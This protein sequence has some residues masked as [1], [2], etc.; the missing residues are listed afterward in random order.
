MMCNR[1]LEVMK[2]FLGF[3]V[4][5]RPSSLEF[6]GTGVFVTSGTVPPGVVTSLYP[7]NNTSQKCVIVLSDET[8]TDMSCETF[9]HF[10]NNETLCV[11][12]EASVD[13]L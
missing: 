2:S 11:E 13:S 8:Q 4:E 7:G 3:T 9:N 10:A 5:K 6:G 1:N 12:T